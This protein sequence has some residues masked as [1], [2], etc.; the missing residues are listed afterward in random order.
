MGFGGQGMFHAQETIPPPNVA[1]SSWRAGIMV[2]RWLWQLWFRVKGFQF[3]G[4]GF[5]V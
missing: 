5:R 2:L 3:L 1:S 4:L